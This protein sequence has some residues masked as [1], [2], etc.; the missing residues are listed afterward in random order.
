MIVDHRLKTAS[1]YDEPLPVSEPHPI[2]ESQ[3]GAHILMLLRGCPA[4]QIPSQRRDPSN[5]VQELGVTV[6]RNDTPAET[7]E[8]AAAQVSILVRAWV[9]PRAR[10]E[11]SEPPGA[12][13]AGLWGRGGGVRR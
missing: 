13:R 4:K 5:R 10:A 8:T 3:G 7:P 9:D 6:V 11:E 1:P 2:V 12:S